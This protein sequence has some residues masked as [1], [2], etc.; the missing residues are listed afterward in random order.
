MFTKITAVE[1]LQSRNQKWRKSLET[2]NVAIDRQHREL[3][4]TINHLI[5]ACT[6]GKEQEEVFRLM[7]FLRKYVQ[8]HFAEE[9]AYQ[10]RN[11]YAGFRAHKAE[12]DA[13]IARLD[14]LD[15]ELKREG[16]TLPVVSK[17]LM[18]T[19]QWLLEHIYRSDCAI[20]QH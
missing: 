3:L 20:T 2:G 14:L 15:G 18:L 12:H 9:E 17:S 1:S 19:Y 4:E 13:F 8:T 5:L 7:A 16:A 6:E 10:Q 11:D